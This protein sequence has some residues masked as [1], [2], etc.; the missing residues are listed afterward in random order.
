MAEAA[1][2]TDAPKVLE[3]AL[4]ILGLFSELR[5]EWTATDISREL[6][7]P[8][9]TAHRIVRTLD[10]HHFL[11]RTSDNR[12]RLG[13]AAISLGRRASGSFDLSEV[14]RP[15]LEWLA[16]ETDETTAIATF[17]E[18]RLGSLYI[19]MIER[20][21]PVRVSIEIGSVMPLHAGAHGRAL[22]AFLGDDVLELVL[23][24]PLE[25]LA[26]RTIT[27]PG[28]LR[29]ELKGVRENGWAFA[30][31]EAHDG[32]WSMAAPVL[33]ASGT[34]VASVGF[35]SPTVRY[36]PEL[37]RRGAEYVAEAARRASAGLGAVE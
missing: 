9:T 21:H 37:E 5:P 10:A 12:Y 17:D 16:S 13:V 11:R 23:K 4:R 2:V 29:A 1:T 7:L 15:S 14:L 22:L 8:L 28:R 3:K 26:S 25:R 18:R 19:D 32:A 6:E 27:Q 35:L 34:L 36:Q 33:D 24:R 31:D 30:R 20:A